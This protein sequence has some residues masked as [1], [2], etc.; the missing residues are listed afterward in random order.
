MDS[1]FVAGFVTNGLGVAE[2]DGEAD[3]VA[4]DWLGDDGGVLAHDARSR[5]DRT[6]AA[7]NRNMRRG[8]GDPDACV[9]RMCCDIW[10]AR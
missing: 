9:A 7:L 5:T 6:I 10:A 2:S 4:D 8:P 1:G 3:R